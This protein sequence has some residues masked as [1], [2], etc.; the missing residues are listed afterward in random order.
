[1]PI[2]E[3]HCS[4]CRHDFEVLAT[5]SSRPVCPACGSASLEKLVSLPAA[6]G[7]SQQIVRQ[8]RAQAAREGHLSNFSPSERR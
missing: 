1:M 8:A 2:Y 6:P 7:R 5:S 4:A 3:Y